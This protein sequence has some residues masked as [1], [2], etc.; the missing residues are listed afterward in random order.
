MLYIRAI[1]FQLNGERF[2]AVLLVVDE[3]G[4]DHG[5]IRLYIAPV[6]KDKKSTYPRL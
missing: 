3:N 6:A 5:I 2:P 4:F 1:S